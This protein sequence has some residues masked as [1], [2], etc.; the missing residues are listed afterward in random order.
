[1]VSLMNNA[2]IAALPACV[3]CLQPCPLET[4]KVNADGKAAHDECLVART[5]GVPL[6][7]E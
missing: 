7:E 1:M 6:H 4:C 2:A 5:L 3:I